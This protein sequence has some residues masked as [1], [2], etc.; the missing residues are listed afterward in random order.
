MTLARRG[1]LID[2]EAEQAEAD[3]M[4]QGEGEGATRQPRDSEFMPGV[5]RRGSAT[6]MM[7]GNDAAE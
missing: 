6:A 3:R 1:E 7:T 4:S 5:R 2:A